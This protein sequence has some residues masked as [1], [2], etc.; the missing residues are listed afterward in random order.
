MRR[1][2]SGMAS[3]L[4]SLRP[5]G[6]VA[7]TGTLGGMRTSPNPKVVA[8]I[9]LNV[10]GVIAYL[11]LA[12]R[13]WIEPELAGVPGASGGAGAVW[14]FSAFPILVLF[15]AL[16]SLWVLSGCLMCYIKKQTWM[17]HPAFLIVPVNWAVAVVIDFS[18]H[19][20]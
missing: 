9:V 6:R 12:S 7:E 8:V 15:L 19:G 1:S 11:A 4:Q 2:G 10:M 17:L 16:D 20:M 3:R 18:Q 5:V 14:F 13:C